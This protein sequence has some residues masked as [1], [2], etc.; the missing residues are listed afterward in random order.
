[1]LLWCNLMEVFGQQNPREYSKQSKGIERQPCWRADWHQELRQH[2]IL[3]YFKYCIGSTLFQRR[4]KEKMQKQSGVELASP[5]QQHH[6]FANSSFLEEWFRWSQDR[7]DFRAA[8]WEKMTCEQQH[9]SAW[10]RKRF[11]IS[12]NSPKADAELQHRCKG[13]LNL[14]L[15]SYHSAFT[16]FFQQHPHSV[17]STY[18]HPLSN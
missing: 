14:S 3:G 13:N 1:M 16:P 18:Q 11:P 7:H 4:K 9:P 2:N 17:L 10:A 8:G 5:F 15:G 6:L 12:I